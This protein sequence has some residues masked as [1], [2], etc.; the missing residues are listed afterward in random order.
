V[1]VFR[2]AVSGVSVMLGR[3]WAEMDR[4]LAGYARR[5]LPLLLGQRLAEGLGDGGEQQAIEF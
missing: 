3:G 2:E 4:T 1:T 5:A